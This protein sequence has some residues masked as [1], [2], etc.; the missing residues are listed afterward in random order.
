MI[1]AVAGKKILDKRRELMKAT[2]GIS[3]SSQP[4]SHKERPSQPEILPTSNENQGTTSTAP[5][6]PEITPV[7]RPNKKRANAALWAYAK[8]SLLFFVAMMIT[9][10]PSTANRIYSICHPG[11]VFWKSLKEPVVFFKGRDA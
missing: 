7:A 5:G 1:Y 6:R 3:L 2:Q 9:W 10:I 4:K 8:V 11:M